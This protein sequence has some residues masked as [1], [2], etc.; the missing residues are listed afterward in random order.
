MSKL[1]VTGKQLKLWN[2]FVLFLNEVVDEGEEIIDEAK[3]DETE[4]GEVKLVY[5][6]ADESEVSVDS[7]GYVRDGESNLMLVGEHL[8]LDGNYLVV[9]A[10]GKFV[11]TR[12]GVETEPEIVEPE[13]ALEEEEEEKEEEEKEEEVKYEVEVN[14]VVYEVEKEV[15]ELIDELQAKVEETLEENLAFKKQ[16]ENYKKRMPSTSPT[17]AQKNP[18]SQSSKTNQKVTLAEAI[19]KLNKR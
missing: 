3:K 10:D 4:S 11:E 7:E 17:T 5:T 2:K 18:L 6:L 14:D 15:K 13:I 1:D 19:A 8:L 12:E 9:D 16:I